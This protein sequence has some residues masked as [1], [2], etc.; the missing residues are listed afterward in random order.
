MHDDET[1]LRVAQARPTLFRT[2]LETVLEIE[3]FSLAARRRA[4]PVRTV[5]KSSTREN[6]E[7]YVEPLEATFKRNDEILTEL[8]EMTSELREIVRSVSLCVNRRGRNQNG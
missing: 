7:S 3:S 8:K 1:C 6:K 4:R 2:A 5:H